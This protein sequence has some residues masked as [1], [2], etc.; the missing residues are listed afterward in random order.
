[1]LASAL[2]VEATPDCRLGPFVSSTAAA[3]LSGILLK[4]FLLPPCSGVSPCRQI[5][6]S[7]HYPRAAFAICHTK[8]YKGCSCLLSNRTLRCYATVDRPAARAQ[9]YPSRATS[10]SPPLVFPPL[11]FNFHVISPLIL[12]RVSLLARLLS[13]L[14]LTASCCL[15]LFFWCCWRGDA[16]FRVTGVPAREGSRPAAHHGA[17]AAAASHL[18]LAS[19]AHLLLA[20]SF[21]FFFS[22]DSRL[23]I[24][25]VCVK[26]INSSLCCPVSFRLPGEGA[27]SGVL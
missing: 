3:R 18:L 27:F 22:F 23:A 10:S 4:A 6:A 7:E 20:R 5:Q 8:S 16:K 12:A 1:M 11:L 15:C 9:P 14:L 19:A 17:A 24:V 2:T 25:W 26:A 13:A 21:L